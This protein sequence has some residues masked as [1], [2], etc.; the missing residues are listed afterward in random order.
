MTDLLSRFRQL[1]APLVSDAVESLGLPAMAAAPGLDPYHHDQG[2][3]VVGYAHTAT[4]RKTRKRVEIDMLMRLVET[5]SPESLIVVAADQDVQGALWGGLMSAG[6]QQQGALGA[7]IDGGVRDLHQVLAL[8]FP[9]W[10]VYRS[11]LDIRGR[12]EMTAVGETV[13]FRGVRVSPGD[14]VL[15]D[16]NGVVVVP[17]SVAEEV[18]NICEERLERELATER[19]LAAGAQVADVYARY[20]AI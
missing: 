16:G 6:V 8:D 2:R 10:A 20:Q 19:E 7:V 15:A 14:I 9:V 3:V 4:V 18:V 13:T 11:P 17:A 5:T 12:A 1:Y